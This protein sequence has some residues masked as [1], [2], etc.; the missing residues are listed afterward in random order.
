MKNIRMA[1]LLAAVGLLSGCHRWV[2]AEQLPLPAGT[3]VRAQLSSEGQETA[4]R[5]FGPGAGDVE[6]PIVEW[7]DE[8]VSFLVSTLLLRD[9]FPAT[10]INDTL[11]I[12]RAQ[13]IDFEVRELD[14]SRTALFVSGV[15]GLA[16]GAVLAARAI[17]SGDDPGGEGGG[18]PP[19]EAWVIRIPLAI[20]GN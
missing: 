18:E 13:V 15:V 12:P 17:S 14:K 11:R 9:G 5:F 16:V 6:G 8:D 10:T 2:P 19:P 3:R 20:G 4:R 1:L 7:G